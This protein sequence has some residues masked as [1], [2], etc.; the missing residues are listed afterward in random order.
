VLVAP[1][2]LGK[3]AAIVLAWLWRRCVA[4]ELTLLRLAYCLPMRTLV[5]QTEESIVSWLERLADAK[6]GNHVPDMSNVHVST[7]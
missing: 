1:T 6:L 5:E 3:T 2:G 7:L 4:P